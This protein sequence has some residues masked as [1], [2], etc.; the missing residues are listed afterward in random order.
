MA[1]KCAKA[2]LRV[3]TPESDVEFISSC[4]GVSPTERYRKGEPISTRNPGAGVLRE[5][6]WIYKSPLDDSRPLS[7]HIDAVLRVLESP[8][9][10]LQSLRSR[11]SSVDLFCM[12]SSES[13]QGSM[14][15]DA[16]LLQRLAKQQIDL[17]I[18][19]YPPSESAS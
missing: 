10:D 7:E 17:I 2:A 5:S 19:L 14:E 11:V 13:G 18:D 15:L 9:A 1:E 16:P 8:D 12:F 6:S 3:F 4:I